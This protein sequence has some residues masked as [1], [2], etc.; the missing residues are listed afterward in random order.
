MM[1][2]V[3]A[4]GE[5]ASREAATVP[6]IPILAADDFCKPHHPFRHGL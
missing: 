3:R 1:L 2:L 6:A 5:R 4:P